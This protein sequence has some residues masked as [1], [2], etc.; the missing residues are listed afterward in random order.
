MREILFTPTWFITMPIEYS[1]QVYATCGY[2]NCC[3]ND[4]NTFEEFWDFYG[5]NED[6][7]VLE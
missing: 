2:D 7:K 1:E 4:W 6:L 5:D 3:E